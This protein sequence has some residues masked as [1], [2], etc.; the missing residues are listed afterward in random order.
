M[1]LDAGDGGEDGIRYGRAPGGIGK[2]LYEGLLPS[3]QNEWV[4]SFIQKL[5]EHTRFLW[6]HDILLAI[7]T[8]SIC[9]AEIHEMVME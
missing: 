2:R 7:L 1:E 4:T 3:G 6:I 5:V 9:W 8:L